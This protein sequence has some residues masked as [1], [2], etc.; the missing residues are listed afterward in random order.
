MAN[1]ETVYTKQMVSIQFGEDTEPYEVVDAKAR[2][3]LTGVENEVAGIPN[4]YATKQEL[5]GKQD[6][7]NYVTADSL[8]TVATTGS[9][10]D[11]TNTPTIPAAQVQADWGQS[12]NSAVDYIKNK[13]TLAT[14]AT[15]GEYS[16]LVNAPTIPVVDSALDST[17][18]NAIE[19]Q[20][21]YNALQDKQDTLVGTQTTGQ[22]IKTING[23]SI[24]GSGNIT[25]EG[26]SYVL[27][28]ASSDTLGG[29]KVGTGLSI[30]G[31]GVLSTSGGGSSTMTVFTNSPIIYQDLT[32]NQVL[33]K[34]FD[35]YSMSGVR[36][37]NETVSNLIQGGTGTWTIGNSDISI[38]VD[39]STST[40]TVNVGSTSI[41]VCD[42]GTWDDKNYRSIQDDSLQTKVIYS[43][44]DTSKPSYIE[45]NFC[46]KDSGDPVFVLCDSTTSTSIKNISDSFVYF[47][48]LSGT[49]NINYFIRNANIT[50]NSVIFDSTY[51]NNLYHSTSV[52]IGASYE[53][54]LYLDS[55]S[56]MSY[57]SNSV[58]NFYD[59]KDTWYASS[60]NI[61]NGCSWDISTYTLT[62]PNGLK[63]WMENSW[64]GNVSNNITFRIANG[65]EINLP[66]ASGYTNQLAE[67]KDTINNVDL[68]IYSTGSEWKFASDVLQLSQ[69]QYKNIPSNNK[70]LYGISL[71]NK[72]CLN[73]DNGLPAKINTGSEDWSLSRYQN[74]HMTNSVYGS[75]PSLSSFED[76]YY[77]VDS[78]NSTI[79][80]SV[81]PNIFL[82][83]LF[84]NVGDTVPSI[85][86]QDSWSLQSTQ[87]VYKQD[88]TVV[89]SLTFTQNT[90]Y[91]ISL[92][93]ARFYY[94]DNEQNQQERYVV[95]IDC[96]SYTKP[97]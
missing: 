97:S 64:L 22:N 49:L 57:V 32:W 26:G 56:G 20:A 94:I 30:N 71:E 16:D 13:P 77:N 52:T 82:S 34:A 46:D 93:S 31:E 73:P 29:V 8:A 67:I 76:I 87:F 84:V 62:F 17:S 81:Q 61:G 41:N 6:A 28:I 65:G 47:N 18:T 37:N 95:F 33:E 48:T 63:L 9:Y 3:D 35:T 78:S 92:N 58:A 14:V 83:H 15:T 44:D 96:E 79:T 25:I 50:C 38:T 23:N 90:Y 39:G 74:E 42:N 60:D 11:L 5:A 4:I 89:N 70:S 51:D 86:F 54:A 66:A 19:N 1:E 2:Q 43:T 88:G 53:S 85:T 72:W 21:V 68:V 12:D 91:K 10:T 69:N 55:N 80:L 40:V 75:N 24:L 59:D 36:F 45:L 7:G 27:P